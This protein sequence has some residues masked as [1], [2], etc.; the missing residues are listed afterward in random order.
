MSLSVFISY[1]SWYCLSQLIT[2]IESYVAV[3]RPYRLSGFY[4]DM[5]LY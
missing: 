1:P 4:P 2:F 5:A 3:S